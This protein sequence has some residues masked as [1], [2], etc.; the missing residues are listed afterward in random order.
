MRRLAI[1]WTWGV[2][3]GVTLAI[4]GATLAVAG[5]SSVPPAPSTSVVAAPPASAPA[6]APAPSTAPGDPFADVAPVDFFSVS[7]LFDSVVVDNFE[8]AITRAE[9]RGSQALVV[10]LDTGGATVS[11]ARMGKLAERIAEAKVPVVL[12]VGDSKGTVAY[13]LPAQLIAVADGTA[14]IPGARL[15]H[16]GEPLVVNGAPLDFGVAAE[17]LTNRSLTL[18]DLL[19]TG[20][21]KLPATEQGSPTVRNVVLDL[22]GQTLRGRQLHTSLQ[23]PDEKGELRVLP[24]RTYFGELGLADE[25]MHTAASPAIAYLMFVI[26]ACLL[27]FEF[28]TAGV[29]VAGVIGALCLTLGCYGLA[30][31]PVRGWALGLLIA[32]F[33]AFAVDTQVGIPR[34]WTAIGILLFVPG[35]LFLF[36]HLPGTD[37][38]V[39]WLTLLVAIAGVVMTFIVGMP[40]MVRTR[41]GTPTIGREWM[42]GEL[43]TAVTTID[44]NGVA[45][46]GGAKWRARVNRATPIEAGG[47]LRVTGIDG[48]TPDVEPPEGAARDYRD[49]RRASTADDSVAVADLDP[50]PRPDDA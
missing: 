1:T 29:G 33:L 7:G 36:R 41:F 39:P 38:R 49:R 12:W 44:P 34:L 3:A 35:S 45:E 40:S 21:L 28:F 4:G 2:T 10:Q 25:L 19:P 50:E 20:L 24:T 32:S 48:V 27:V 22:D 6:S 13:G 23:A 17:E 9:Q 42:I 14:M 26:G 46:V 18:T 16:L 31:L 30:E 8:Q 15:G 37:L 11:R 43:G 47:A 5:S